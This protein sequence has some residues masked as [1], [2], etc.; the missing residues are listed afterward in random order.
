MG[1]NAPP[2]IR[3]YGDADLTAET[4]L[5]LQ[6]ILTDQTLDASSVGRFRIP[7][8]DV[9]VVD[10]ENNI[11]HT[12]PPADEL[13]HRMTVLVAFANGGD[14]GEFIHPVVRAII[15]HFM[16]GYD[17]PF[18]DGNGRTARA[19]FYWSMAKSKYRLMEFISI[20]EFIRKSYVRYGRAYL[21][22]E[23]DDCDVTYFL[24]YNL[25]IIGQC[26]DHLHSYLERK[27]AER[28]RLERMFSEGHLGHYLNYRQKALLAH[29]VKWPDTAYTIEGHRR[30]HGVSYHTARKDL[31]ELGAVDLLEKRAP[32]G[33]K[34]IYTMNPD[35]ARNLKDIVELLH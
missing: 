8:D 26:I 31:D 22:S 9:H 10:A 3:D 34:L 11:L 28:R 35:F 14:E 6:R 15:L 32:R 21:Y 5:E 30:S 13:E 16:I 1:P 25:R 2:A 27:V 12:P 19:L 18:V 33:R 29:L 17:H 24:H 23:T 7:S 4:V 20:S